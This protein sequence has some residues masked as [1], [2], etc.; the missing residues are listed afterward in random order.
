MCLIKRPRQIIYQEMR[1]NRDM[2]KCNSVNMKFSVRTGRKG[3]YVC[4]G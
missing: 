1:L 4:L 2:T 3:A